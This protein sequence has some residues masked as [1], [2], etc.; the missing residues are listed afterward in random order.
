MKARTLLF[1]TL[2]LLSAP[3]AAQT[4]PDVVEDAL[5]LRFPLCWD[6]PQITEE[7][8][9]YFPGLRVF[10]G[11]CR[12]YY[13]APRSAAVAIDDASVFYLLDTPVS[14]QLLETRLGRPTVDSIGLVDYGLMVAK[15]S[16]QIPWDSQ[17]Q[18]DTTPDPDPRVRAR[19]FPIEGDCAPLKLPWTLILDSHTSVG[20]H[21]ATEWTVHSVTVDFTVGGSWA[22]AQVVCSAMHNP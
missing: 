22:K 1:L 4:P 11:R 3:G 16:G 18:R 8:V 10:V 9:T 7:H 20:F 15:L 2:V 17:L 12:T 5:R 19:G 13:G 6:G 14:F 21:V